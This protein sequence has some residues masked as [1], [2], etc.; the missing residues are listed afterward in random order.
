VK[1]L[2]L[3]GGKGT[4]LRPITH[5]RAKQLIP[6]AN[7]PVLYYGIEAIRDAGI[8]DIGIV[9]G[10]TAA[11][12]KEAVGT[13]SRFNVKV[14][15][16]Q[17]EEPLGLAHAV[18]VSADFLGDSPFVMYLG[19]NLIAQGITDLVSQFQKNTPDAMILLA[20]VDHPE[21]FG[22]AELEE[23]RVA[24][25]MEKPKRPKS[26]LA[27]VG[28]YMFTGGVLEAVNS[29]SPS[30]RGELEIT[31]AIQWMVDRGMRVE[32]HL[33]QGWWKDTGRVED[34]LEA[35]R[36]V[37]D[38]FSEDI[39]GTVDKKSQVEFKVKV[40]K[41]ARVKNSIIR[42]P[43]IIGKKTVIEN[44]YVGPFTSINDDCLV[45]DSEIENSI[46]LQGSSLT[47]M[48]KR[49]A[50]SLI[51]RNVVIDCSRRRPEALKF[52]VGESSKVD[53]V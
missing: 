48:P 45:L 11:E 16:I 41:G 6:V 30:Q 23:G 38:T 29:I 13:G 28:V 26:D 3:S 4:R 19:D 27:L 39:R 12:V 21:W 46:M 31:D 43:A 14:T 51:G 25:L 42:G 15:Y 52:V 5:T 47:N 8:R 20:Q 32:P 35:N 49:V 37:L 24:R 1:G 17:Q 44:S 34:L 18:K 10:D 22:V 2:I 9:V 50:D 36:I 53:L 7:Q 33:V 40:E